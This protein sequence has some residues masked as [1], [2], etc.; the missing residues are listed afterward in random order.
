MSNS[1]NGIGK[2]LSLFTV[3]I[4]KLTFL[5]VV[6]IFKYT[7][8]GIKNFAIPY[9]VSLLHFLFNMTKFYMIPAIKAILKFTWKIVYT[10]I[11]F[12]VLKFAKVIKFFGYVVYLMTLGLARDIKNIHAKKDVK[13][14]LVYALSRVVIIAAILVV[15]GFA[16]DKTVSVSASVVHEVTG[17]GFSMISYS[18]DSKKVDAINKHNTNM[19]S[20]KDGK[21]VTHTEQVMPNGDYAPEGI[22]VITLTD[23]N[24]KQFKGIDK[25]YVNP[26]TEEQK[27][28]NNVTQDIQRA[29]H[30][31]GVN[32]SIMLAQCAV[33]SGMGK[34]TL[35]SKYNNYFGVKSVKGQNSV[36]MKTAEQTKDGKQY[37]INDGF[38]VYKDAA[39][40]MNYN[41]KLL[42]GNSIYSK[43]W[44]E[45]NTSYKDALPGLSSY[46]TDVNYQPKLAKFIEDNGLYAMDPHQVHN[47]GLTQA[48]NK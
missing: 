38:A 6:A 8:L 44:I 28:I 7:Y 37:Y 3:S 15:G 13:K 31:N 43:T 23:L 21:A 46:A 17:K 24:G 4:F 32:P 1:I 36:T 40:S 9:T 29:A 39:E 48:S 5:L 19:A 18:D 2:S 14:N 25:L 12:V 11:K 10:I 22:K 42:R 45:N 33:E 47:P 34:S 26:V 35:A 41:G 27:F 20:N 30:T 16:V